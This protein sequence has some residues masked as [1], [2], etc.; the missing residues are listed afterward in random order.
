MLDLGY[1]IDAD[2]SFAH[3]YLVVGYNKTNPANPIFY[4]KDSYAEPGTRCL[5]DCITIHCDTLIKYVN[6]AAIITAVTTPGSFPEVKY[7]GRW[8]LVFDGQRGILDI[9]HIPGITQVPLYA[10]DGRTEVTDRRLGTFTASNGNIYRVNGSINNNMLE[11][12]FDI[13]TPNLRWDQLTGRKFNYTISQDGTLM[14]GSHQDADTRTYGGYAS[15]TSYISHTSLPDDN[16]LNFRN[17][18]WT[19][20]M[21]NITGTVVFGSAGTET[22]INGQFTQAG[23]TRPVTVQLVKSSVP[24]TAP[25]SF[26][27][28]SLNANAY[29]L[30]HEKGIVCGREMTGQGV[31]VIY[32]N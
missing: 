17:T 9:N 26:T 19:L 18:R 3:N 32:K 10:A 14:S 20:R 16:L 31:F 6:A 24:G 11:F 21:S 27:M 1:E 28:G 4:L 23:S 13:A 30:N 8:N 2:M 5:S 7:L 29:F 15:R 22:G 25:L 12:Y